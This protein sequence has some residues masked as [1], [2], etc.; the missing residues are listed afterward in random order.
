MEK[1]LESYVQHLHYA[2]LHPYRVKQDKRGVLDAAFDLTQLETRL[3]DFKSNVGDMGN[4]KMLVVYPRWC[5]SCILERKKDLWDNAVST[6]SGKAAREMTAKGKN[7]T[8]VRIRIAY[9]K[10]RRDGRIIAL[11]DRLEA[12][13]GLG[14]VDLGGE[15]ETL[16]QK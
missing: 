7:L 1:S 10:G 13:W 8:Q 16:E 9:L 14:G 5:R 11:T 12:M 3:V 6:L 15:E 4:M 2:C